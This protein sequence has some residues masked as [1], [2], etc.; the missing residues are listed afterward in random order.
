[1]KN[2]K[3]PNNQNT[4]TPHA[5]PNKLSKNQP[6][7]NPDSTN[8]LKSI[9]K[10]SLI[11]FALFTLV[12]VIFILAIRTY[13]DVN[14]SWLGTAAMLAALIISIAPVIAILILTIKVIHRFVQYRKHISHIPLTS[15]IL[16]T[17]TL[18]ELP[19]LIFVY[20]LGLNLRTPSIIA[21]MQ[22]TLN[23]HFPEG[24]DIIAYC[25]IT[26]DSGPNSSLVM[27]K[28][29]NYEKPVAAHFNWNA[30]LYGRTTLYED[31]YHH[32]K[33]ADQLHYQNYINKTFGQNI[34]SSMSISDEKIQK[35]D[36][37]DGPK[38]NETYRTVTLK[39][40]LPLN[41]MQDKTAAYSVDFE[42]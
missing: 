42:H 9:N 34:I 21:T 22:P 11:S 35:Y 3:S 36:S 19:I 29:S 37:L 27:I 5:K 33:Q 10:L 12:L 4:N 20:I 38:K 24:Y 31:N 28:S 26:S 15:K 8:I 2:R 30:S 13:C 41:E 25:E 23:E 16:S 18:I 14:S 6:H 17:I 7:Q 39:I 32:L 1:M 40:L